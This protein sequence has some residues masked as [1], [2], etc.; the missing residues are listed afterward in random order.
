MKVSYSWLKNYINVAINPDNI[1]EILTD[2]G[3]EIDGIE[4]TQSIKGGLEGLVVGEVLSK[5]K[6]PDADRLSLTTVN[7]GN[8]KPLNIVCGAPNVEMGQKV[9]VAPVGTKLYPSEGGEFK[10]KKS[11]IRGQLSEGMICAEDEIGLGKSHEGIMVLEPSVTVGTL[12]KDYFN[13]EDDYTFEIG[14]TPNRADGTGHIGVARDLVAV[15]GQTQEVYLV[16][17]SVNNFKVDNTNLNI[18]VEVENADLCPRYSGLTISEV[19]VRESP[20]WLKNRL[21]SIGLTPI[22]NVVDVTNFVLHETGQPLH[23]FDATKITGNKVIIKT[24]KNKTKFITL[25]EIERELSQNDL[26]VCN[27][28][29][30]MCIAGVF[31]GAVSGVS[32]NTTSIFLESAYFNPVSVRKSAKRHG[33]NTDASF[34]FERGADPNITVYALK[35]AAML[36]KEVA[37]GNISSEIVDVYPN[38]IENFSVDFSYTN[39]NKLIG[40]EIDRKSIKQILSALEIE[41]VN[42]SEDGLKLSIPP[43]KVDVQREID[44][45]EEVLRIYGYNNIKLPDVLKT[46]ISYRIKPDKE[47][48][49]NIISDLLV[50]NGFNEMISNSL[51]K[52]DYYET[53][54]DSL[55]RIQN[56]LSKD[57]DVLRQSMVYDGL[58]TIV[59]NQNRR[60]SDV[61]F[62][63]WGKTYFKTTTKFKELNHLSLFISGA[64]NSENWDT[65]D[66]GSVNFYQLKGMVHAIMEKF[67]MNE[68]NV[69]TEE[70]ELA[71]LSYGLKY[72]VNNI[73]IVE[74]GNIDVATQKQ[75][76]INNEVFYVI[77][78]YDNFMKLVAMNKV[79]YKEVSKFPEVRRDLALLIDNSVEYRSIKKLALKQDRKLLKSIN[80]FDVYEGKNLE[81]GKKSYGVSF[82]FQVENKTL[83][84]EEI[85]AVMAKIIKSLEIELK[86]QLR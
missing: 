10:I 47:K 44:V 18:V 2:S 49:T 79:T 25:D 81:K 23:S 3:L 85:D 31:G 62:F 66:S 20:D 12:A 75:F 61:K 80:L 15:L 39:C 13:V 74:F 84:D 67:G 19:E 60:T 82:K 11:K 33:L 52:S 42:E 72:K 14:L 6:H 59:Y 63:E 41:V 22:N 40:Q 30:E 28:K 78:D 46:S 32:E 36:I 43:F 54:A 4:K 64:S 69:R 9:I 48:V 24:A 55:V 38:P 77:F 37:G 17:P 8:G 58:E 86:A 68:F 56:P 71:C 35:R 16:K 65:V 50:S 27:A 7:V 26:M 29:D 51:T 21:L 76:D 73:D 83:T 1:S 45:I 34:R 5:T 57:L 70:S 53:T